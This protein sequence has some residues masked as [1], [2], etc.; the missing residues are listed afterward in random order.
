M[1]ALSIHNTDRSAR[2]AY[3]SRR[4]EMITAVT[5]SLR[6]SLAM[7]A[8][9]ALLVG[10]A[11]ERSLVTEPE[12]MSSTQF[13]RAASAGDGAVLATLRR[14]TASYHKVDNA[15][16]DGYVLVSDCEV[17]PGHSAAGLLY[18]NM[19]N[20]MDGIIDPE[21]PE[22]LLYAPRENAPPKLMGV[23]LAIPYP[24]WLEPQPPEFL[25]VTFYPEDEFGVWG[26]HVWIWGHNPEGMFAEGNPNITC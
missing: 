2:L 12:A 23:D 21:K 8:A 25:G 1:R 10:C 5:H 15:I 16:A 26:L 9:A 24:L 17:R 14:A 11:D 3:F 7:A 22:G 19:D 4:N 20:L 13:A 18:A 6:Q